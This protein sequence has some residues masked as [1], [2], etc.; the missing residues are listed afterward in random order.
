VAPAGR[1]LNPLGLSRHQLWKGGRRRWCCVLGGEQLAD[2]RARY[3]AGGDA[4]MDGPDAPS[5]SLQP[6]RGEEGAVAK[7][8]DLPD[9]R[10]PGRPQQRKWGGRLRL[11]SGEKRWPLAVIEPPAYVCG[12]CRATSPEKRAAAR[13]AGQQSSASR[14]KR[15]PR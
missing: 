12:R 14:R 2:L 8:T 1:P 11:S 15:S 13:A 5:G 7:R 6:S 3:G 9:V 4:T 10:V